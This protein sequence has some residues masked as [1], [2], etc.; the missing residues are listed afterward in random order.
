M[1]FLGASLLLILA[2]ASPA[3]ADVWA[4][5]AGDLHTIA[6]LESIRTQTEARRALLES[7]SRDLGAEIE[8]LKSEPPG[9]RRDLKL[10]SELAAQKAKSDE[11][12]RIGTE[13]RARAA[14]LAGA[15]RKLIGDC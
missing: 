1:R 11:L 12:E 14:G 8:R 2:A 5:L 13:L 9:V 10:Q 7:Q 6:Q 15:R 3:R 4:D